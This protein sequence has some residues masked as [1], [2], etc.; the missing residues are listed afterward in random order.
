VVAANSIACTAGLNSRAR[1]SGSRS[2]KLSKKR[3]ERYGTSPAPSSFAS[4]P[5]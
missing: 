1:S 3:S 4:K 2:M 5:V